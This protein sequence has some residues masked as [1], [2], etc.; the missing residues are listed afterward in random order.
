[1]RDYSHYSNPRFHA[2]AVF[3]DTEICTVR[4][5]EKTAATHLSWLQTRTH[6]ITKG[7]PAKIFVLQWSEKPRGW[8]RAFK[9]FKSNGKLHSKKH[10]IGKFLARFTG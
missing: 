3:E 2:V 9:P 8:R 7:E 6:E 1:M 10:G 5:T 4:F